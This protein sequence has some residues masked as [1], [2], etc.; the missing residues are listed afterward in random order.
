MSGFVENAILWTLALYGLFEI[1]KTI[2]YICTYKVGKEC[3]T[4]IIIATKNQEQ[5]IEGMLRSIIFRILNEKE[6]FIDR[7]ILT[8]LNSKDNTKEI[9]KKLSNDYECV[10][11]VENMDLISE[12]DKE[13]N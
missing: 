6:T 2:I 11:F 9:L 3:E 8:D 12:L 13:I 7:I 5:N 1:I 10:R 4:N